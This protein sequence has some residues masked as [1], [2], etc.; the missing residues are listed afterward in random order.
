MNLI[1][2]HIENACRNLASNQ[3]VFKYKRKMLDDMIEKADELKKVGLKDEKVISDLV[4]DEFG[5]LEEK[6]KEF[7]K[8][9]KRK[10]LLKIG[11]PVGIIAFIILMLVTY[12]VVSGVTG[13]WG[14]TW[15]IIVGGVFGLTIF[16]FSLLIAK[17]CTMRR[18]F[19][20]IARALIAGS[21]ILVAVFAF[22]FMLTMLPSELLVWPTLPAG[23]ILALLGDLIFAYTTKQKLRT[24]SFFVYMPVISTMLYVILA[25]YGVFPWWAGWPVIFVGLIVDF[26]YVIYIVAKNLKYFTYKQ[27]VEE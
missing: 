22:L 13:A 15:L 3:S 24:I 6:Y 25:A 17:L 1:I 23:V 7:E 26:A 14:K 8:K 11:L 27:E 2:E 10:K 12:F 19:H 18:V 20:P 16:L 4:S 9:K 21:T 5:N